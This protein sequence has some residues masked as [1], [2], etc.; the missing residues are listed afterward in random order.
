M[1]PEKAKNKRRLSSRVIEILIV[2]VAVAL[3]IDFFS[4]DAPPSTPAIEPIVVIAD[5]DNVDAEALFDEAITLMDDED[6]EGALALINMA[7]A[8][9]DSPPHRYFWKQAWLLGQVQQHE[10]AIE[11]YLVLLETGQNEAYALGGLCFNY[12]SLSD[13]ATATEYCESAG[14]YSSH[15]QYSQD[16]MCY[17]HGFTGQYDLAIEE[18]TNWIENNP[19][20]YAY[21][22]RSRAY[23]MLGYYEQT[24]RDATRSIELNTDR[25]EMPYT[26]RGIARIA[27]GQYSDGYA[28]L[29]VAFGADPTYPDIYL[30]LGMYHDAMGNEVEATNNYCHYIDTAWAIPDDAVQA[31]FGL[32]CRG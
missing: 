24:I 27:L 7:I 8:A 5:N 3:T 6:Y 18:C 9:N 30:G 29:M 32:S 16:S 14:E 2:I 22:N 15:S 28:D 17:I 31:A 21:N 11:V 10:T 4:P 13:F 26:N 23:L 25:P 19:H 1:Q 20:P 12:G